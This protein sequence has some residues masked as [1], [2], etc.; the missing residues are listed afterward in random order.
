MD[1][2]RI[3]RKADDLKQRAVVALPVKRRPMWRTAM[4]WFAG[5]I[6][7]ATALGFFFDANRGAA[8]RRMAVDQAMAKGRDV[9]G[10][11]GRKT[12]H[13]RNKAVGTVAEVRSKRS[14]E[15]ASGG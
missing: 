10:W 15:V 3:S 1:T 5:G 4:L 11:S 9:S 6:A 7:I 12:R 2:S 13:L 8:R 14:R